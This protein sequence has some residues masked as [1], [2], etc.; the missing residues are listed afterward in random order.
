M[1]FERIKR[2]VSDCATSANGDYDPARV[3]GYGFVVLGGLFFLGLTVYDTVVKQSFDS[4]GFASG[5]LAISGAIVAAG[6]GVWL[7]KDTEVPL[8]EDEPPSGS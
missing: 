8:K 2:V 1:A 3:I 5:L 7:K 4:G 6:A